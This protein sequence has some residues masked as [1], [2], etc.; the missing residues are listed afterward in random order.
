MSKKLISRVFIVHLCAIL[1][2]LLPALT[3]AN[4]IPRIIVEIRYS[5]NDVTKASVLEQEMLVK[6]GDRVNLRKIEES[7][8]AIMDLGLFK[9]V[10]SELS[11][12]DHGYLLSIA[13]EEKYYILPLP[14]LDRTAD[15]EVR[16]GLQLRMDNMLGLNHKAKL[17]ARAAESGEEKGEREKMVSFSYRVPRWIN[18]PY[19]LKVAFGHER[20]KKEIKAED[21]SLHDLS[22]HR[23]RVEWS[24]SRFIKK[25]GPSQGWKFSLGAKWIHEDILKLEGDIDGYEDTTAVSVTSSVKFSDLH[26]LLYSKKGVEYGYSVDQGERF[27]G[28]DR[29]FNTH[30]WFYRRYIPLGRIPHQRLNTQV[31]LG[32]S[33]GRAF[34]N[35]DDAFSLGGSTTLRGHEKESVDGRSFFLANFEY[36]VPLLSINAFRGLIF[37]DV[38]NAYATNRLR[39]GNLD[40]TVG[41][42]VRLKLKSFI[43][44]RLRGEL[45]WGLDSDAFKIYLGTKSAF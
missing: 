17:M 31:K 25:T 44:L 43:R 34:N 15:G 21:D 6:R 16:Y 13:V 35:Q 3:R 32:V 27:M 22:R 39:F 41:L 28:G 14:R 11:I 12:V 30:E 37:Y 10:K 33:N 36:L 24:I 1:L 18:S 40:S 26:D 7:R 38:G 5:G 23:H 20:E 42:G 4:H 8:Q 19:G 9:S 45:A 29:E 2:I